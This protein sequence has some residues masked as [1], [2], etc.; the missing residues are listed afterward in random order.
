MHFCQS[1]SPMVLL[2]LCRLELS[3]CSDNSTIYITP[4]VLV[5]VRAAGRKMVGG[6]IYCQGQI[7]V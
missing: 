1:F 5:Y 3:S 6:L 4:M 7:F 2:K